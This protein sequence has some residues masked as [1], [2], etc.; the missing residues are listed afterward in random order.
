MKPTE[1]ECVST[2]K[3]R[4]VD[5][6]FRVVLSWKGTERAI[7][8]IFSLISLIGADEIEHFSEQCRLVAVTRAFEARMRIRAQNPWKSSPQQHK[9]SLLPR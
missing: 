5:R 7:N 3:G 1:C 9:A 4:T 2:W 6:G 8:L